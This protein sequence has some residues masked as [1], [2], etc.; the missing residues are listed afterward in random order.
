MSPQRT[1]SHLRAAVMLTH[2]TDSSLHSW[3]LD[4]RP[5]ALNIQLLR[6]TLYLYLWNNQYSVKKSDN[7]WW[8][9]RS[10]PSL[11]PGQSRLLKCTD[12][13]YDPVFSGRNPSCY[14][15]SKNG[16]L[17]CPPVENVCSL[18]DVLILYISQGRSWE[19]WVLA[20]IFN[21]I[22]FRYAYGK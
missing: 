9:A 12:D 6:W 5:V 17:L 22:K 10:T 15:L 8:I 19:A 11:A 14:I 16:S 7:H 2:P 20:M 4:L 1:L 21:I 13:L 3:P 18:A